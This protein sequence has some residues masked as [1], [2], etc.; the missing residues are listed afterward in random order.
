MIALENEENNVILEKVLKVCD[1]LKTNIYPV[2]TK[3]SKDKYNLVKKLNELS[4]LE[5]KVKM[6]AKNLSNEKKSLE[7][8]IQTIS[9]ETV[10]SLLDSIVLEL[11]KVSKSK[12]EL[13]ELFS[14]LKEQ[15]LK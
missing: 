3:L 10:E 6:E 13:D 4:E 11:S 2:N 8:A 15:N 1:D 12:S 14:N 9:L 7:G 5:Q